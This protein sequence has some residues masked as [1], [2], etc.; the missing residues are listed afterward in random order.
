M[1]GRRQ[2][3]LEEGGGRVRSL[4]RQGLGVGVAGSSSSMA[5]CTKSM[6][7]P[8]VAGLAEA[9]DE[10]LAAAVW[11]AAELL[12]VE[13]EQLAGTRPA[14]ATTALLGLS[15]ADGSAP[16]AA[17]PTDAERAVLVSEPIECGRRAAAGA[18]RRCGAAGG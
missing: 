15:A 7:E 14:A 12:H 9:A 4:V 17:A 13:V 16:G 18:R 3:A 11:D 5:T 6:A 10:A 1:P 8:A 2:G